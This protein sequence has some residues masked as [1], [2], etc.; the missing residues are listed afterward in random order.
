MHCKSSVGL[1]GITVGSSAYNY[2]G[3]DKNV[4]LISGKISIG[5]AGLEAKL[6]VVNLEINSV[7]LKANLGINT[8]TGVSFSSNSVKAN[9]GGFGLKV[10]KEMGIS[11]SIGGA[12]IDLGNLISKNPMTKSAGSRIKEAM[13]R[14]G[15]NV[16]MFN[17]DPLSSFVDVVKTSVLN[18]K[19]D[20]LTNTTVL[21]IKNEKEIDINTPIE[22]ELSNVENSLNTITGVACSNESLKDNITSNDMKVE[23][24]TSINTSIE[25]ESRNIR[26]IINL[27]T[28]VLNSNENLDTKITD[29]VTKAMKEI[30]TNMH[31]GDIPFNI[32]DLIN[33][34]T[35]VASSNESIMTNTFTSVAS[36]NES[37]MTNTFTSVAS[38]NEISAY[39][40]VGSR[41]KHLKLLK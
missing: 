25:D 8:S 34:F 31:I 2:Q 35:S 36:I 14:N 29:F 27:I 11:T 18:S 1:N 10:G 21:N 30:D 38:I 32:G 17:K 33:S 41:Y 39:V 6:D 19:E 9:I 20:A 24:E 5:K 16:E 26:D 4:K 37:I 15:M 22:D 7:G 23:N 3:D 13:A 28:D 40:N 12:S